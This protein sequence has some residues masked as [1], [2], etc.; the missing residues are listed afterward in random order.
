MPHVAY[1][2]TDSNV[3]SIGDLKKLS[4]KYDYEYPEGLKLAPGDQLHSDLINSILKRARISASQ[5]SNRFPAWRKIDETMTAYI[6]LT[7]EEKDVQDDDHRK[8]VSIIFPYSYAILETMLGYLLLAYMQSPIF[9]FEGQSPDDI[10]GATLLEK[11]IDIHAEKMKMIL[12][13]HTLFRDSLCYGFGAVGTSWEVQRG[14]KI[15]KKETLNFFNE[16]FIDKDLEEAVIFEGNKLFNIDPYLVLPDPNIALGNAQQGEFFGWISHDHLPGLLT[17]EQ[18]GNELFNVRY[19][20]HLKNRKTSIYGDDD[21]ARNKKGLSGN[22]RDEAEL[23]PIDVLTFNIKLIPKEWKLGNNEYPELWKIQIASDC[24]IINCRPLKYAHNQIPIGLCAPDFDGYS[25]APV[26]RMEIL[27]GL[28][29]TLDWFINAHVANVRKAV[30]DTIIV[31]PYWLNIND[32]KRKDKNGGVIRTRKQVWGKGVAGSWEQLRIADVTRAHMTD[33][34]IIQSAM[35]KISGTDGFMMGNLRQGGP[36][37][38]T[39]KEF[40]G[41]QQG[42]MARMERIARIIGVQAL[43]DIG[44]QF[45][46]N[47]QQFM[48]EDLWVKTT[49][50]WQSQLTE[51]Y[52]G[53]EKIKV[54][55]LDLVINYDVKVRDGSIPG[56]NFSSVWIK[57]FELISNNQALMQEFDIGRIFTHIAENS[58]AKDIHSFKKVKIQSDQQVS[59][60]VQEG[61]LIPLQGGTT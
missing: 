31:D 14:F 56:G 24:L 39:G 50:D 18:N 32:L 16:S 7:D 43:Q 60:G 57:L 8:P 61:N 15:V 36:E 19:L 54:S 1:G 59:Q 3:N 4:G 27:Y 23:N 48:S 22:N 5:M 41:T 46:S 40:E 49:G 34:A 11:V 2:N 13:L 28:Q 12:N 55:P 45:A 10:V 29:H 33:S 47:T 51:T 21:T 53:A 38:L 6:D 9:R 20:K 17:E 30:N 37:R 35:D 52:G 25:Q 44:N 42:G 58:G 26:S